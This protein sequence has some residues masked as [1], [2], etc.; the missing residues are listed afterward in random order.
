MVRGEERKKTNLIKQNFNED[1]EKK[2]RGETE[3]ETER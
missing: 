2:G 3:T 1:R